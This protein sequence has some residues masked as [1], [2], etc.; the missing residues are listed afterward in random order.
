MKVNYIYESVFVAESACMDLD[1]FD[2][3]FYTFSRT[4]T[5]IENNGIDNSPSSWQLF[6]SVQADNEPKITNSSISIRKSHM[7]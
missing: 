4:I 5:G 7:M 2:P 3:A 1:G 6:S